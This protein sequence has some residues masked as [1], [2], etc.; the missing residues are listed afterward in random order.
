MSDGLVI[1]R[2]DDTDEIETTQYRILSYDLTTERI[3]FL[4]DLVQAIRVFVHRL[5]PLGGQC[6]KKYIPWH[7]VLLSSIDD[8][9]PGSTFLSRLNFLNTVGS[10]FTS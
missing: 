10:H 6:A 3:H 4:V 5:P 8:L 9:S 2:F 1:G 7:K